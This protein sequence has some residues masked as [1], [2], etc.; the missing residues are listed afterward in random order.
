MTSRRTFLLGFA[1]ASLAMPVS[2]K[3]R[4]TPLFDGNSLDGW[5]AVG[6]ANWTVKDGMICADKG[7]FSF[8]VSVAS[9]R[10]FDLR[11]E[12]WVSDDA[13]SGIFIR[14]S[15]RDRISAKNAYEVN[16]FDTRPDPGYGTGAIVDVA[17]V[18]PMPK[19]GGRWNVMEIRA[20]GDVFSVGLNGR[21]TVD[22][23]RDPAHAAGPIA[24]QYGAGVVKFRSVGIAAL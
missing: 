2:A 22:S 21:K 16:I 3:G 8:L 11:A 4:F 17:K 20:R 14:C 7:G 15:D 12:F 18:F 10:D 24:L 19:A 23:A 6:D 9:Y 5:T 13:N 1:A